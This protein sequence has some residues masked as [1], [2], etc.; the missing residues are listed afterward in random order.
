MGLTGKTAGGITGVLGGA[1]FSDEFLGENAGRP[2]E[3]A[4]GLP[5]EANGGLTGEVAGWAAG[6]VKDGLLGGFAGCVEGVVS[7][8]I[9]CNVVLLIIPVAGLV[10]G[11]CS[12]GCNGV[13]VASWISL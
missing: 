1:V 3:A 10:I 5:C 8:G 6:D 4:G 13:P 11:G 2:C 7:G 12:R 9:F